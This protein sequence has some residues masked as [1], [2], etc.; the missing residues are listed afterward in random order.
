[1]AVAA[2]EPR[3]P[4]FLSELGLPR[5]FAMAAV[6][7]LAVAVQSTL[8]ARLTLLGVIPQL[9]LVV[10][11]CLAYLDGPRVGVVLGFAGGLLQDL[12]LP[13]SIIGLTALVYTL[14]GYGVGSLRQFAPS[15]SVWSPVF[16]V[17][18]ASAIAEVGYAM[19]AIIL[20]EQWVSLGFTAQVTGL[21]VLY[22]TLLTPFVFPLL[23]RIANRFR[24]EKVYR[25]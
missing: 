6:L 11:V 7:L 23:R 9:V 5:A 8:L 10:V 4:G 17:A 18:I 12:L 2:N 20:G 15:D 22:D 25:W 14:L 19:L 16:G 24:P 1:M 3:S 13:Q 21:V